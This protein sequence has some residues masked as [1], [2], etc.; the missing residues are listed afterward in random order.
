MRQ[1]QTALNASITQNQLD[2]RAWLGYLETTD[3]SVKAN[4]KT[5]IKQWFINTGKTP[6]IKIHGRSSSVALLRDKPFG[7]VYR[8]TDKAPSASILMP[9]QRIFF[10]STA[11]TLNN[12]RGIDLLVSGDLVMYFFGELCYADIFKLP[13]YV[14]FCTFL[15][16]DLTTVS[17]C[18]TYNETDDK[19]HTCR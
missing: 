17:N 11:E 8:E 9:N 2:Q 15:N 1:T 10:D 16:R 6:A 19:E 5:R 18:Q 13:H 3:I 4:E 7:P 12:Q 14:S